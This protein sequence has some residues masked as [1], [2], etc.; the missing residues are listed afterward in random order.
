[1]EVIPNWN[2]VTVDYLKRE[3]SGN[4]DLRTW[5]T[6]NWL[7][8]RYNLFKVP[9]H[10]F[11]DPEYIFNFQA[12]ING[13]NKYSF[14]KQI[15]VGLANYNSY[16]IQLETL[17]KWHKKRQKTLNECEKLILEYKIA[18]YQAMLSEWDSNTSQ[19]L[20]NSISK[21]VYSFEITCKI[22]TK[23]SA[24]NM[25][26]YYM[27]EE[28]RYLIFMLDTNIQEK[29]NKIVESYKSLKEKYRIKY[30]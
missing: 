10:P 28:D 25:K 13:F 12:L 11:L 18:K 2:F 5:K 21:D 24:A 17:M 16:K 22:W 6:K 15:E 23:I 26:S 27:K 4:V 8:R 20:I 14:K 30:D 7:M 3:E 1:L 29:Y 9:K 19:A